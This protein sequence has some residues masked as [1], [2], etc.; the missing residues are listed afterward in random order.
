M[1][2]RSIKCGITSAII[3]LTL[4]AFFSESSAD[5]VILENGDI[6]TG[7]IVKVM[8]GK[9]TLKTDYSGPIE[10]QVSKIKKI[11]TDDPAEVHLSSGEVLKG[12]IET[13]EDGQVVVEKSAE[14]E[15]TSVD[16]KKIASINPPPKEGPKWHGNVTAGGYIQSGNTD[17]RGASFGAELLRRSENDRF[18]MRYI[19]NYADEDKQ[20][21]TRNNYGEM[22]YDYFFTK[23]FYGFVGTELG[24]DK[25]NDTKLKVFVGPGIGYQFWD[26][27]V[28]SL[29]FEAG[30]SYFNW[31]RY[32][33]K[34]LDGIAAR[35]GFDFR[36]NI[37]KWLNFTDRYVFYP[38]IGEGGMYFWRNEAALNI[39]LGEI[40][41]LGG[42]WSL[43]FANI[44]D[45][46][47]DPAPGYKKMDVQWIGGLQFSF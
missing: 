33:G 2:E 4:L 9:L 19:F 34:D 27:P 42:R 20:V 6:L 17:R 31:N 24:N 11:Y 29:L 7:N 5:K 30:F 37:F 13:K 44:L 10:I 3:L 26:D 23:K 16:L 21:T 35:L 36:Y 18:K 40:P 22:K 15:T 12:K 46:N 25:F 47:S 38:T 39:P 45:F 32:E 41:S 1:A 8:D 43:K 14:R 28:K